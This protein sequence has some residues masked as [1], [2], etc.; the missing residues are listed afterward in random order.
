M[1]YRNFGGLIPKI[2]PQTHETQFSQE[3]HNLD[4]YSGTLKS[5]RE[6]GL[7]RHVVDQRG[8]VRTSAAQTLYDA[9]GLWVG[10]DDFTWVIPDT[11]GALEHE[12]FLF[13]QD[14]KLWWQHAQRLT[15]NLPPL[16]VGITPPC[17][18]PSGVVLA[19]VGCTVSSPALQCVTPANGEE[20]C[21]QNPPQPI[22]YVY[23]WV[24][25][26]SPC[27][28][29]MEE[30]LPSP[31]LTI[32]VITGDA[33]ALT[34]P[35]LP[36]DVHAVRWY[37]EIA[38]T[39]G[40]VYLFAGESDTTAF[41]DDLCPDELGEPLQT[42]MTLP[43]PPCVD[44]VARVGDNMTVLWHGR[45]IYVSEPNKP[46]GYVLDRDTF[47]IPYRVVAVRGLE[48]RTEDAVTYE[49]HV[50]TEGKP[51]RMTGQVPEKLD[52]RETQDWHP[53]VS[54][55]SVCDMRGGTGY[56]S[57]YG[58]VRF[59]GTAVVN[60]SDNYMTENEW[61]NVQPAYLR[62]A[63]WNG[64]VWMGWPDKEGFAMVVEEDGGMRPKSLVTHDVRVQAFA[65]SV[66]LRLGLA[67]PGS[68]DVWQ[69]GQGGKMWYRWHSSEAVQSG[70]WKPAAVKVISAHMRRRYNDEDMYTA[71]A[72]WSHSQPRPT[73]EEFVQQHPQWRH[74]LDQLKECGMMLVGVHRD[75]RCVYN[76][77]HR[78]S[79]PMRVPR[80]VRALEWS[81]SVQGY[82]EVREIHMQS[83][84]SDMAQEGGM[85]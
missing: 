26:Y 12:R 1:R 13:V 80:S 60:L 66:N 5:L 44:G 19:N 63:Y 41:L 56:A 77:S 9:G 48:G 10:F 14:G 84:I 8:A 65:L 21:M 27:V 74:M 7:P 43:P 49:A 55:Q 58:F 3:A 11:V 33:V 29:R 70:L 31:P 36:A 67:R 72:Q 40:S 46:H 64:R 81:V 23:T 62:A 34:S 78:D 54:V 22:N 53:C 28:G 59:S 71:Y 45:Q 76:R 68:P 79:R 24:R 75:G 69:W 25:Y 16:P 61:G 39:E 20:P 30:S 38:G 37:R 83:S 2:K 18:A 42:S 85:A 4:L 47:D 51:Y 73:A 52:I 32:D 82:E 6:P 57:P 50:L 15:K 35:A 17:D